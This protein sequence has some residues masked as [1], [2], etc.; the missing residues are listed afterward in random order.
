MLTYESCK[1]LSGI[2]GGFGCNT[3]YC[4]LPHREYTIERILVLVYDYKHPYFTFIIII[5]KIGY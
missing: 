2:N 3:L 5:D 1:T 4:S